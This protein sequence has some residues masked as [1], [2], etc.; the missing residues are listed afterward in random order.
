M[1]DQIVDAIGQVPRSANVLPSWMYSRQ[2]DGGVLGFTPAWVLAYTQ[3]G[4][5]NRIA[6]NLQ[7]SIG[8]QLNLIDFK[9]DR[10]EIERQA[11][12]NFNPETYEWTPANPTIT[13]FDINNHYE[14]DFSLP[15]FLLPGTGYANNDILIVQGNQLGGISPDN[16]MTVRVNQIFDPVVIPTTMIGNGIAV[17]VFYA[18]LPSAPYEVGQQIIITNS[19]PPVYNGNHIVT[20]CQRTQLAFSSSITNVYVGNAVINGV[21]T[22]AIA[23]VFATGTAP[24]NSAG[25]SFAN[26]PSVTTGGGIDAAFWINAVPGNVTIFDQGSMQFTDGA[27]PY[28][29]GDEFDEYRVFPHINILEADGL[30]AINWLNN[31]NA[32]VN[33]T[34]TDSNIVYWVN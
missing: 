24:A 13:T 12:Y 25:N 10:Y 18:T 32:A 19:D 14:I 1:R 9:V 2:S 8:N 27:T 5:G 26:V 31:N 30:L 4:Q 29:T 16:D 22:G 21:N 17:N 33:W 28:V 3:P 15:V 7:R 23:N 11:T 20:N 6:Y 34:S